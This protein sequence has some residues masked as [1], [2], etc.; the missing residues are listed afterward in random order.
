M[1]SSKP[2]ETQDGVAYFP[3]YE[4]Q[5]EEYRRL[6]RLPD[7]NL[8]RLYRRQLESAIE[9]LTGLINGDAKSVQECRAEAESKR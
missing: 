3:T 2:I 4:G 6:M 5:R 1:S 8:A 9:D 7:K